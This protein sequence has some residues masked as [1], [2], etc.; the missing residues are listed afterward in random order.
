MTDQKTLTEVGRNFRALARQ[1]DMDAFQAVR[2]IFYI[3]GALDAAIDLAT[4]EYERNRDARLLQALGDLYVARGDRV[5][6]ECIFA[7]LHHDQ[8]PI[9]V[10]NMIYAGLPMTQ[11]LVDDDRKVL[12][13]PLPKCGSSSVKNYFTKAIYDRTYGETVHFQHPE[14]YRT[15]HPG[16][17]TTTYAEYYKF[18]VVRDPLSRLVSYYMLNVR[19]GSL[20]REAFGAD[21]VRGLPTRPTPGQFANHFH[22]YR[23]YFKDFRHHTDPMVG[24]LGPFQGALDRVYRLIELDE[25]REFLADRYGCA[26]T[27]ERAMVSKEDADIKNRTISAVGQL[28][29]VYAP[30]YEAFFPK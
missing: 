7:A 4:E 1:G 21:E 8:V 17:M 24:Y 12:F 2:R 5:V 14:L 10:T 20:R 11:A 6:A 27:D 28:R 22:Q 16:E 9:H 3:D 29:R 18:S 30:D 13:I 26:L 15:I 23:Q 19:Q 25:V